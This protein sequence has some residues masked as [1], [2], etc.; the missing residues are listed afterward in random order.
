MI[1]ESFIL[2]LLCSY[3]IFNF[4]ISIVR[5]TNII[6]SSFKSLISKNMDVDK[7]LRVTINIYKKT[8]FSS[9]QME[10]KTFI[11]GSCT[12]KID[13]GKNLVA[14]SIILKVCELSLFRHNKKTYSV[15]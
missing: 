5:I 8:T 6:Q 9:Y 10:Q 15:L 12:N 3:F 7:I 4:D 11:E 2:E 13:T 1:Y 14:F